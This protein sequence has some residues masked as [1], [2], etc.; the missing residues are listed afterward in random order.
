[1]TLND[2]RVSE[3]A[4]HRFLE[5]V[6]LIVDHTGLRVLSE[7]QL[8]NEYRVDLAIEYARDDKRVA[9]YELERPRHQLFTKSG[10][11]RA[12]VTHAMTQVEDWLQWWRKNPSKVPCGLDPTVTPTGTVIMGR[13]SVLAPDE[14]RRLVALNETRLVK[15]ITYDDLASRL[16]ALLDCMD[17]QG[18]V[19]PSLDQLQN[20]MG[21]HSD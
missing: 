7:L 1:M 4:L 2:D 21:A 14:Q 11:L 13:S 8:G 16:E 3:A 17:P 6:P 9:L 20:I 12:P 10:R 18:S 5:A 15:L 19:V